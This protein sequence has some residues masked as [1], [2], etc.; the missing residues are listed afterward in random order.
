M[1][2]AQKRRILAIDTSSSPGFAVLEL[3]AKNHAKLIYADAVKTDAKLTDAERYD[4]VRSKTALVCFEY[5]PFKKVVREHFIKGGSKRGTQLVFGA[6]SAVD[7]ALKTWGYVIDAKDEITP[8]TVKKAVAGSGKAQ[9]D[10]VESGVRRLL[11]LDDAYVFPNNA[12]GDASDAAAIALAW[13]Q[14]KGG[15]E[16]D[17]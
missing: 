6:W 5:G 4:V 13:L 14:S 10:E 8:T 9:K 17:N 1:S 11:Q 16:L 2:K 15:V 12:G 7:S 3:D